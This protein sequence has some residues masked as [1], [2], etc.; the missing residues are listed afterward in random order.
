MGLSLNKINKTKWIIVLII[1]TF[2]LVL[3]CL[4]FNRIY[5]NKYSIEKF[6]DSNYIHD[7]ESSYM[8]NIRY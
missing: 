5:I 3:L 8:A 2:L 4:Y 1:I 6:N 7:F